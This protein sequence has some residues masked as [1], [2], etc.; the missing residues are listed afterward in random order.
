M[1][2]IH[3]VVAM[4]TH[5]GQRGQQADT[6]VVVVTMT[7]TA[8]TAKT[9]MTMR[10]RGVIMMRRRCGRGK[11]LYLLAKAWAGDVVPRTR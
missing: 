9:S 10:E 1:D 3:Q 5:R 8:T 7:S 6:G 11:T 4:V 2:V